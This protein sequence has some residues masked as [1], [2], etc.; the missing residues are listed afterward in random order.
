M[1]FE[2]EFEIPIKTAWWDVLVLS[3]TVRLFYPS[4][5]LV[6][7]VLL[8]PLLSSLSV[9]HR[10]CLS[11]CL[12]VSI[13]FLDI[14]ISK[15]SGLGTAN[16]THSIP[17]KMAILDFKVTEVKKD[18]GLF[19]AFKVKVVFLW[20]VIRGVMPHSVA[21]LFLYWSFAFYTTDIVLNRRKSFT[22]MSYSSIVPNRNFYE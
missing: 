10:D 6:I 5:L 2:F 1:H 8:S 14:S 9:C 19:L 18:I 17:W 3:C 16:L 4:V 12:P 22:Q 20:N 15:L 13:S 11:A 21:L 7:R